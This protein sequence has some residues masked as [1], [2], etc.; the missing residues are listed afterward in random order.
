MNSTVFYYMM[1]CVK[2]YERQLYAV[3]YVVVVGSEVVDQKPN[4]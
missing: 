1:S 3:Q 2:T 4:Y